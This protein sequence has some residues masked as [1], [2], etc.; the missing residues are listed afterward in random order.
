MHNK[1]NAFSFFN[2]PIQYDVDV[3]QLKQTYYAIMQDCHPDRFSNPIE[4]KLAHDKSQKANELYH[5]LLNPI[6]RAEE[7]M[8]AYGW[9]TLSPGPD[10]FNWFIDQDSET[11]KNYW[12]DLE[13]D[14]AN[15]VNNSDKNAAEKAYSHMVYIK[16]HVN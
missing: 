3:N 1:E 8:L 15:A 13:K 16:N 9:A 4:K 12:P 2:V 11:L 14:F 7:I 6:K 5:K 10:F